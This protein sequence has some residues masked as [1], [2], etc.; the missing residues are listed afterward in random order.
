MH[1]LL[2]RKSQL[3]PT[4]KLLLEAL[5]LFIW[6]CATEHSSSCL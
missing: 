5:N 1:W 2:G 6:R 3:S 4:N